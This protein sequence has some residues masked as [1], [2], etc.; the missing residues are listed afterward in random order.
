M[1]TQGLK[2]TTIKEI[3]RAAGVAEGAMY[4]HFSDKVELIRATMLE[5]FPS[6]G[7]A[8]ARLLDSVGEGTV[9]GNLQRL[10]I[11]AIAG[12]TELIAFSATLLT[13]AEVLAAIREEF[14][15]R[16]IG[17]ARAHDGLVAYLRAETERG[18]LRPTMP[19][20]TVSVALLGACH[21]YAY[22]Q[23]MHQQVP[24]GDEE[25]FARELVASLVPGADPERPPGG[26]G[27]RA[28]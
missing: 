15:A 11:E 24:F 9:G 13:D 17:P 28:G 21:E 10:V 12:Y 22:I 14:T 5:R 23:V 27:R 25:T 26:D 8:L 18:R 20:M 19:P 7:T 1:R 2:A 4:R 16:G 3:A 6:L